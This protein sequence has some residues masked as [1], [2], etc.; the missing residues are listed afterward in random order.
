MKTVFMG[1][2]INI[3]FMDKNGEKVP[4]S[5]RTL[6]FVTD[7]GATDEDIGF[8]PFE[9]K[10]KMSD[11]AKVLCVN[12]N[13]RDV[14]EALNSIINKAVVCTFAPVFGELKCVGFKLEK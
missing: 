14:N 5:S 4:Y 8:S 3:G 9:S 7:M 10:F 1:Y 6:R 12:A 13:D 11:L 2:K